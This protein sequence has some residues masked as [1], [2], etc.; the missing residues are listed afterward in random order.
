MNS[1]GKY[2][3]KRLERR[4]LLKIFYS[5]ICSRRVEFSSVGVKYSEGTYEYYWDTPAIRTYSFVSETFSGSIVQRRH[6]RLTMEFFFIHQHIQ[7]PLVRVIIILK[8]LLLCLE[9]SQGTKHETGP[10]RQ[11]TC[12]RVVWHHE[13]RQGNTCNGETTLSKWVPSV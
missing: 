7:S 2:L 8:H 6:L 5:F 4:W 1:F 12:L 9:V 11:L 13:E 3:P 10:T